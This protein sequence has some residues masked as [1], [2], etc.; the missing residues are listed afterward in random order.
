MVVAG[1][2]GQG[3]VTVYNLSGQLLYDEPI[4]N[5]SEIILEA[6]RGI[7]VVKVITDSQI[8]NYKVRM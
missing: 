2:S 1:L 8:Y 7:Y 3:Q 6:L 5:R 4:D